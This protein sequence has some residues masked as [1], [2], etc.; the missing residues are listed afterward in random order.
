MPEA[1]STT[2]ALRKRGARNRTL[3]LSDGDRLRLENRVLSPRDVRR[4]Q[5]DLVV[6]GECAALAA[7][8][9]PGSVDL[10]VLDPPYNLSKRF[11]SSSFSAS[12]PEVYAAWFETTLRELL[13]LLHARSSVYVF[14]DWRNS[15][16]VHGVLRRH[17][18]VQSRITFEREKGRGSRKRWKNTS[19]DIWF[20]TASEDYPFYVDQV[21][22]RRQVLAPY[23]KDGLA[24]G[25]IETQSGP[26]RDTYPGN[27]WND[28]TIPF[29]SMPENTE[30]PTQKPEKLMARIILASSR[31]GDLVLDP[32]AGSGTTGVVARKLGR[33]FV[34]GEKER[35]YCLLA[36]RRLEL[37]EQDS[38][39][40]GYEDGVFWERNSGRVRA[41]FKST[42]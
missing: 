19:E 36:A 5:K 15:G 28:I 13:P 25:W 12:S 14:C 18:K 4:G 9:K 11:G 42:Q 1:Q 17:L 33:H 26:L 7:R 31:P 16:D 37:A 2:S 35:E 24:R 27:L 10:L 34:L 29:W 32:F 22:I 40:Q 38:R 3:T 39:I 8:M 21:M 6:H 41:R 23:T 20:A 30:H